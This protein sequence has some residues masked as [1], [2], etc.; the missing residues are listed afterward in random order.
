MSNTVR[1]IAKS[2]FVAAVW[3]LVLLATAAVSLTSMGALYSA[4]DAEP[5]VRAF[6][7]MTLAVVVATTV[8]G[9]LWSRLQARG[10]NGRPERRPAT[11]PFDGDSEGTLPSPA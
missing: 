9:V 4:V 10:R 2:Y 7:T 6:T 5:T 1:T 8:A 3:F 11:D